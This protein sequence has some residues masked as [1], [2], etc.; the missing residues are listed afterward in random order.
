MSASSFL[1]KFNL[2]FRCWESTSVRKTL[3]KT[4]KIGP[5]F[6]NGNQKPPEDADGAVDEVPEMPDG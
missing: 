3:R 5:G 1:L 6:V 2:V 4:L